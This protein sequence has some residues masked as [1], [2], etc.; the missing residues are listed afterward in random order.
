MSKLAGSERSRVLPVRFRVGV[1]GHRPPKLPTEATAA[2]RASV[3]RVLATVLDA[4]RRQNDDPGLVLAKERALPPTGVDDAT[5]QFAVI[6]SL[7]EGADRIVAEAGLA[8]GFDLESVLPF[9]KTEYMTDFTSPESRGRF[10]ELLGRASSVFV[11]DSDAGERPRAYEA[12]GFVMLANID[13][14]IAIWDGNE[15]AGLG[16]TAQI[17]SR[18]VA[19]G[20]PIVWINP[21]TPDRLLLSWSPPDEIP[22]SASARPSETFRPADSRGIVA[23]INETLA[24]PK[25]ADARKALLRFL[26]ERERRWNFCPW[27]PLL[28]QAFGVRRVRISDFRIPAYS[29]HTRN[30]WAD[31]LAVLSRDR[32]QAPIIESVL[33][34]AYSM[35]D[36]LAVYYSLVY[37]S[38]YVFNFL[39]ASVAVGLALGGIFIGDAPTKSFLVAPEFVVIMGVLFTWLYGRHRQWHQR[40]L[41]YRRLAESLRL[42]RTL[43]LVGSSGPIERPARNLDVDEQDWVKWYGWSLRRLLPLPDRTIDAAYL[44]GLRDTLRS[45]EIKAQL[46]YHNSNADRIAKLDHR[47]HGLGTCLFATTA[48]LCG[49][50]LISRAVGCPRAP[51]PL[52]LHVFTMFTALLPNFGAA[53]TAIQVQGDFRTV[54]EQSRRTARR[55]AAID[56]I[57]ADEPPTFARLVDRIEKTAD[58]MMADLL[59]WQLIFRTRPLSLS[60]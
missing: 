46:C 34:P 17:V 54:A 22:P 52:M 16:G 15:Q 19:D 56:R 43:A 12:A 45:A 10:E 30:Q 26:N 24:P 57:V 4:V 41:D 35:A 11:L 29:A 25:Q 47:M 31:Y 20:I 13:L 21:A 36:H 1:S 37:R 28:L 33:L 14:L 6:S 40:W 7:A 50:F 23:A 53:L 5:A 27:Y 18:A 48:A 51:S 60:A 58:V 44:T 2:I 42:M 8:A 38:A 59:E 55:L 3:D 32:A 49:L 39:F 9:S